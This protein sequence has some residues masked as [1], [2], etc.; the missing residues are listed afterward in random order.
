M[1]L[2]WLLAEAEAKAEQIEHSRKIMVETDGLIAMA[3]L[4][5]ASLFQYHTTQSIKARDEY[6]KTIDEMPKRFARLEALVGNDPVEKPHIDNIRPRL[7]LGIKVMRE[8]RAAADDRESLHEV[9]KVHHL[10]KDLFKFLRGL[11]GG[12]QQV[13]IIE[14][15]KHPNSPEELAKDRLVVKQFVV[16]GVGLNIFLALAAA[17]FLTRNL[18][19]RVEVLTENTVRLSEGKKLLEPQRG[20]DEIARLD[21]FFH[22][23]AKRLKEQEELLRASEERT[24]STI[25]NMLVGLVIIHDDGT[26]DS[27]N[28]RTEELF[29][30][31]ESEIRGERITSLFADTENMTIDSFLS[32]ITLEAMGRVSDMTGKRKSGT[33]PI[34]VALTK[35]QTVE[36]TKLVLNILDVTERYEVERLKKELLSMVSHDLRTPLTSVHSSLSL[37]GTGAYGKLNDSGME[38]IENSEAEVDRLI[39]LIGDLLDIARMEAGKLDLNYD[40]RNLTNVIENSV[41]AVKILADMKKVKFK[42]PDEDFMVTIDGDRIVQVLVNLLSNA[43]KF[44]PQNSVI[45]I[46][47]ERK[48]SN[49]EVSVSDQGP[50][51][52]SE[53]QNRIFQR[54]EQAGK[55]SPGNGGDSAGKRDTDN[56]DVHSG[57]EES[58]SINREV[59]SLSSQPTPDGK[60]VSQGTGLG[61][62]ICRGIIECH[63]G[64]IGA[65]NNPEQGSTFWFS[66]PAKPPAAASE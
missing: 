20:E 36:G 30:V 26:I 42:I 58:A 8:M 39:A 38:L 16:I 62:A 29:E 5:A 6:D 10:T 52:P 56:G 9:W 61:L 44:S 59:P 64:V 24:R 49:V 33:F 57:N 43:L 19:R 32:K 17:A 51:I 50:G 63:G 18:T 1:T 35:M 55:E 48:D 34:E 15:S 45:E 65:R 11:I 41:N 14:R 22:N 28:K 2:G 12:M 3:H 46:G 4:C 66:V 40:E 37:L 21:S 60:R 53:F 25:Q 7:A 23:M 54:F 47:V 13:T 31:S 27:I